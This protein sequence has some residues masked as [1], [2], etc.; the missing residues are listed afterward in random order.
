MGRELYSKLK[1]YMQ[2]AKLATIATSHANKPY[3][4]TV[5][6]CVDEN[7]NFYFL[8]KAS[9]RHSKE[10]VKN[11]HVSMAIAPD[12]ITWGTKVTGLTVEGTCKPLFGSEASAAFK[13]YTKRFPIAADLSKEFKEKKHLRKYSHEMWVV[14]P[15]TIKVWDESKYGYE[16]KVFTL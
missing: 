1:P 12:S 16:G 8:S 15:K 2:R 7:L 10:I 5:F 13:R 14:K 3:A 9:R 4:V 6:Y 11:P